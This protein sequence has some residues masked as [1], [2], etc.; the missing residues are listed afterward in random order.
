MA[1]EEMTQMSSSLQNFP[2]S[3]L[4][5]FLLVVIYIHNYTT[6]GDEPEEWEYSRQ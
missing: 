3:C 1:H 4:T 5:V 6:G 2:L